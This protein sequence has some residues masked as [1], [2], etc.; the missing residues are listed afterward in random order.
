MWLGGSWYPLGF[1]YLLRN[2][3]YSFNYW[4]VINFPTFKR[5]ILPQFIYLSLPFHIKCWQLQFEKVRLMKSK[6]DS[7]QRYVFSHET[8]NEES[9]TVVTYSSRRNQTTVFNADR[10]G[11]YFWINAYQKIK[12]RLIDLHLAYWCILYA[13][14]PLCS[15]Y[16]S[17]HHS[18]D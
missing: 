12:I 10:W 11:V 13:D 15:E 8:R 17:A 9:V 7:W 6:L 18:V 4:N 14:V 1:F 5:I 3:K 16:K 2:I